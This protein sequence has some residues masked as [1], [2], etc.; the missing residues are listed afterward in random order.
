MGGV[1]TA[2][3]FATGAGLA[4]ALG[5]AVWATVA[6]AMDPGWWFVLNH[7]VYTP[8]PSSAEASPNRIMPDSTR[9]NMGRARKL[10]EPSSA[11]LRGRR[12]SEMR[13]A[14][15][16]CRRWSPRRRG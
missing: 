2:A 13:S 15:R 6:P 11:A 7:L 12:R 3:G 14:V 10:L 1:T 9:A 5:L 8:T 4:G 16:W